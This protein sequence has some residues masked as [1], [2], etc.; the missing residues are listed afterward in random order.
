MPQVEIDIV[1]SPEQG[2]PP[3]FRLMELP[4]DLCKLIESSASELKCVPT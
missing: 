3:S 4:P 2:P 1:F